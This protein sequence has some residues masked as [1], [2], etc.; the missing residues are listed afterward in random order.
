[1]VILFENNNLISIG[2]SL[3]YKKNQVFE[4]IMAH[5]YTKKFQK[6]EFEYINYLLRGLLQTYNIVHFCS[7][8]LIVC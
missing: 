2:H 3:N 4:N 6:S 1:M 5:K 7:F 8:V